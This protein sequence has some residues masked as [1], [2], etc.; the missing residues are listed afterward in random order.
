MRTNQHFFKLALLI[1]LSISFLKA[2]ALTTYD[3]TNYSTLTTA[4]A[5]SVDGD[6]INFKAHIVVTASISV[7][8]ALTFQ[9]N[10]YTI[11]VPVTGLSDAGIY[12]TSPSAFNVFNLSGTKTIVFNYLTIKGGSTSTSGAAVT[13]AANTVAKFNYCTISNARCSTGGGGLLNQGTC[14]LFR[15][16]LT[17][18]VGDYGGGM[19]NSGGKAFIEYST[20]NENRTLTVNG[21]GGIETK[22]NGFLYVNNSSFCNNQSGAGGAINNYGSKSIICNTSFTGNVVFSTAPLRGGA[23]YQDQVG[24]TANTLTLVNCLF[25]YN[26]YAPTGGYAAS[27]YTIDDIRGVTGNIYLYYCT[28]MTNSASSATFNYVAGNNNHSLA[29]NGS[30]NDLFT[31]GSLTTPFDG[32]GA[33]Q[34]TGQVFQPFLVNING[35][36]L[37]TLKTGSYAIAKGC[38]A[39]FTNGAG[40]P[41]IGYKDM[42]TSTWTD[43]TGSGASSYSI[44]DDITSLTRGA[45]PAVGALE[46]V[47][48]NYVI[49]KVNASSNGTISGASIYGDVYPSGTTVTITAL[50]AASYALNNWTYNLGG[51]G[52]VSG[53][54]LTITPTVNTTL[55]PN[56]ISTTNYT[57]TYLGNGNTSGTAPAIASYPNGTSGSIASNTGNLAKT[58]FTF[59]GWNTS[60]YGA[61]TSYATGASYTGNT[62]IALY[63]S[64]TSLGTSLGINLADFSATPLNNNRDVLLQW[65]TS[66]ETSNDYFEVLRSADCTSNWETI[67]LVKGNGNSSTLLQYSLIDTHPLTGSSCYKLKQVDKDGTITYF[68]IVKVQLNKNSSSSISLYPNPA[69]Q[70]IYLKAEKANLATIKIYNQSGMDVTSNCKLL[71][72]SSGFVTIAISNLPTGMYVL[73]ANEQSRKFIKSGAN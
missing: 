22:F 13:I 28:Y 15:S 6:I 1:L 9:G 68:K 58:G 30:T 43:L 51:S 29:G 47:V 41:V 24:N 56:F 8:K 49:L 64:W 72:Q 34:G 16:L 53:N 40:T 45:M 35:Q 31:G 46:R 55:T 17:R 71:L 61:G 3:V 69:R 19:L 42:S 2:N 57:I 50:P 37:P 73:K 63:A 60:D 52:T 67:G 14:Y 59:N 65:S 26:Y 4:I 33:I 38:V 44:T 21:G 10:G 7:T 66:Q 39:G 18:N 5:S 23:I 25:A 48:D 11:T 12:N 20:V 62:N 36:R 70:T 32:S 54:P 27:S